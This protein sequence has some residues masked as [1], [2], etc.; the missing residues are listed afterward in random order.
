MDKID[1]RNIKIK[2]SFIGTDAIESAYKKQIVQSV[3]NISEKIILKDAVN[4]A[5]I[6]TSALRQS[7]RVI[8][9]RSFSKNKLKAVIGFYTAYAA[10]QHEGDFEHTDGEQYYLSNALKANIYNIKKELGADIKK[11]KFK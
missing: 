3:D 5:P 11:V 8:Y 2:N 9:K 1:L 7:G 4:R 10:A 6:D